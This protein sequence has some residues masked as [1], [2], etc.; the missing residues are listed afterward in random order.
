MDSMNL[1]G[2]TIK[3]DRNYITINFV[4]LRL[5]NYGEVLE[6]NQ[7][8][9]IFDPNWAKIWPLGPLNM[10]FVAIIAI[11]FYAGGFATTTFCFKRYSPNKIQKNLMEI[12]VFLLFFTRLD[13]IWLKFCPKTTPTLIFCASL[14]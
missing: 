7:F 11:N 5:T 6:N 9:A 13:L 14:Q 12:L 8:F 3:K 1:A 10:A 4:T 2:M